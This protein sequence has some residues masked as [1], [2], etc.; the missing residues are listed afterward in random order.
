MCGITGIYNFRKE[1]VDNELLKEMTN[2]LHYRG[3]DD[4]GYFVDKNIG[5]G[6]RRLSIIDLSEK[7]SQPMHN[8]DETVW[9]KFNGE[10]YNFEELKKDLEKKGHRFYSD[11]DTETIVHAY[12]EY[13]EDCVKHLRG[14]FAFSIWDSKNKK[15]FL[16]RDRV[17]KKP[18]FYF[19]DKERF[20]FASELKSLLLD[21]SIAK[22]IDMTALSHYLT[23]GYVPAPLSIFKSIK[24]VMPSHTLTVQDGKISTR[25]YWDITYKPKLASQQY[26]KKKL[27]EELKQAVK[28]RMISDVPL[29]A[30]LSGGIDSSSIVAMMAKLSDEPVKTFSIG[31][32]EE[33]YS[34]LKYARIVAE[35]FNTDHKEMVVRPDA[36]E[37]LPKLVWHYNEPFAD[38][39]AVPTYYLSKMT[40]EHVTVALNGD[41]GDESFAGYPRY[42]VDKIVRYY[43]HVPNPMRKAF[44]YFA[45]KVP[46]TNFRMIS[47]I[48]KGLAAAK[49]KPED[50]YI[51]VMSYFDEG[52]LKKEISSE[53]LNSLK[54][55][56]N[57]VLMD[58]FNECNSSSITNRMMYVDIKKYIPEDL[59]VKVDIASM[60]NSLEGRSPYLDHNLMEFA[61]TIPPSL[62]LKGMTTKY[63]LKKAL[64]PLL[65][66]EIIHRRKQG[67]GM[68]IAEWFRNDLKELSYELLVGKE[69]RQRGYFNY[70]KIKQMLDQHVSG[71][72]DY[73]F[74]L[75]S[76]LWLE[77]WHRIY[78]D[79]DFS[80]I[81]LDLNNI[82]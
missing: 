65:P 52:G 8:E 30:F 9:V 72:I 55:N 26:F 16:A 5:L 31:F 17:G 22:E 3:P 77:L 11:T 12:E 44:T 27:L 42:V 75:W 2:I 20:V 67:F 35:K 28:L 1:T 10:I 38:Q 54:A 32:D 36:A 62:K 71:K 43:N 60:A 78:V 4:S 50:R 66:E 74:K 51:Y 82:M 19:A 47:R 59:M 14:M 64:H 53:K 56:S 25:K 57:N 79:N 13:G 29:G 6:H 15:L 70:G 80:K 24:K 68:P 63:I 41:G 40:R 73:C 21:D 76:L 81:K 49:M 34:E 58:H 48:Q 37:I 23:F 45:N 69:A 61:A 46:Y 33:P 39:A 18:I 7:G